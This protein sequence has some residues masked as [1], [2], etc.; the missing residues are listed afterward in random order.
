[1]EVSR[2]GALKVLTAAAIGAGTGLTAHGYL[3]ERHALTTT[4]VT[5]PVSGLSPAHDG[6][7]IGFLTDLHHSA[8][9]S[10][11]DIAHA[12]DRLLGLAPDLIVLG[13]DYVTN[14]DRRYVRPCAEALAMLSAPHGV[15]AI[16]GNHDDERDVASALTATGFTVLKDA[17][18]TLRIRSEPLDLAGIGFW[19][20]Q[21]A[22]IARVLRGAAGTTLLLAH[23]P[24]RVEQAAALAVPAVLSGHTHGGQV[25]LPGLGAIAARRFPVL[26][27]QAT[28]QGTSLLVSRGLGTVFLPIRFNCPP[29]VAL[30]T[31]SAPVAPPV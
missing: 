23:D 25:V 22:D 26:A 4:R 1:M 21:P 15:F 3:Y 13:G 29:E 7:R 6:L 10:Q 8:F 28:V 17:R 14:F 18:T 24:R 11:A 2:R 27:G 16:L 5:L 20:K 9:V 31:L 12:V 30:I 19:T